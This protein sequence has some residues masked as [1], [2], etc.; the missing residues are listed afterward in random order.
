MEYLLMRLRAIGSLIRFYRGPR[1]ACTRRRPKIVIPP[2]MIFYRFF[3]T[4]ND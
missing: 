3:H 4:S 1:G 2:D